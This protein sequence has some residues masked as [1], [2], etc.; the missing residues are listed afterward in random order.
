MTNKNIVEKFIQNGVELEVPTPKVYI[1][2]ESMV[3]VST[4]KTYWEAPY[5][6][7][8]YYTNI[9]VNENAW[10]QWEEWAIYVFLIDTT[11]V[12]ASAYRNIRIKIWS[13]GTYIPL[14]SAWNAILAGS[15]YFTK[16]R[17]DL[18]VY[19]TIHQSWW[20]L[21]L[22]N[23]TSYSA[24][25]VAE[26]QTGTATS[27]RT[28]RADYLKQII[29]YH[30]W[31]LD[32]NYHDSSKYDASNPNGYTSNQWTITG[33]TM[34]GASKGTSGVV[35]LWTV[36]TSHQNIKTI[37]GNTMTGSWNVS[38][39]AV[40]SWW[41]TWQVLTKN[42]NWYGWED[43]AGGGMDMETINAI[44]D[45]KLWNYD[46]LFKLE[47]WLYKILNDLDSE[48]NLW[49]T[50]GETR[51]DIVGSATNMSKVSH[52]RAV[53]SKVVNSPYAIW[54]VVNS[55]N[56]MKEVSECWNSM[57]IIASDMDSAVSYLTSPYVNTYINTAIVQDAF[58]WENLIPYMPDS[59][60]T[61][62]YLEDST[63]VAEIPT[64][65]ELKDRLNKMTPDALL[66][67]IF[68][69]TNLSGYSTFESLCQNSSAIQTLMNNTN[70]MIIVNNNDEAKAI[71]EQYSIYNISI[72]ASN[73]SM[74]ASCLKNADWVAYFSSS[75]H[76]SELQ[77]E[78]TN[79][80]NT[81]V[82]NSSYFTQYTRTYQ[83]WV[84][85]LNNSTKVSN[86]IV[87][88]AWWYWSSTSQYSNMFHSNW[89]QA[90]SANTYYR[91]TS[92]SATQ[93]SW[94]SF[95]NATFTETGDWYAAIAVYTAN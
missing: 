5:N 73:P 84:T 50:S 93:L 2:D 32:S 6:T 48:D 39:N 54:L 25:S 91:P 80:Y 72:V 11:M 8:Y 21:H 41:T 70:A 90:V 43:S 77:S 92:V 78:K 67:A 69:R 35:D 62:M 3:T 31:N 19:K 38:I 81:V 89:V 47:S 7:S 68:Y 56:A 49:L 85:S 20:A 12:V 86:A 66:P 76:N 57:T 23:D 22:N 95:S 58:N 83:D 63:K 18:Y 17:M 87:F 16:S 82:N 10:I 64:N 55:S 15:S 46:T 42:A 74:L 61:T 28:M 1:I 44:I 45:W 52:S 53:M 34:N 14:M 26:W 36:I 24:M 37:N 88:F 71:Y 9:V 33:I 29:E 79:L 59:L 13:N 51:A 27:A 30:A 94:V 75:E 60:F 65:S 4:T 40:P